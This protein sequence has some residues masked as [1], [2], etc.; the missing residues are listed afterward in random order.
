MTPARVRWA[1]I[2][3]LVL[4]AAHLHGQT[5]EEGAPEPADPESKTQVLPFGGFRYGSPLGPSLYGG[6]ML[7]RLNPIGATGPSLAGEVGGDGMRFSLGFS[8]VGMGTQ[9]AQ[10][11]Y[12]R[13]WDPHGDVQADQ[14]YVGPEIALGVI[15]GVTVGYY[16]RISDGGGKAQILSIG[17]FIGF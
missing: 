7:G 8:S 3:G 2:L 11:S 5:T 6:V 16:W 12:I 9:R 1:L 17:S 10:L 15:V 13:M 4:N 14:S